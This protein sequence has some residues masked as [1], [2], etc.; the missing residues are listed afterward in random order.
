M[1]EVRCGDGDPV[2]VFHKITEWNTGLE[3]LTGSQSSIQAGTWWYESGRVLKAHKHVTNQRDVAF[4]QETI[5]VLNGRVRVD[6]YD[7]EGTIFH[8][9]ELSTG[10]IGVILGGG[11]GYAILADDTKIVEVKNGPF[12][13]VEKDKVWL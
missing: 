4:T 12:V 3:F 9:E 6:L 5:V 13:S 2:A 11:H 7:D 8:Q 10:D 1:R